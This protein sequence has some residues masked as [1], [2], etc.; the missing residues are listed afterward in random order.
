MLGSYMSVILEFWEHFCIL[1]FLVSLSDEYSCGFKAI[2][3]ETHQHTCSSTQLHIRKH[4]LNSSTDT[5]V[6]FTSA[7]WLALFIGLNTA[8]KY[9]SNEKVSCA[10]KIIVKW[11]GG[12]GLKKCISNEETQNRWKHLRDI[13]T[14][15]NS[16]LGKNEFQNY[17]NFVTM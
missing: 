2:R 16:M 7:E 8:S 13:C 10:R 6:C 12:I 1:N 17:Q 3:A 9:M 5:M 14:L 11:I 15:L 4:I